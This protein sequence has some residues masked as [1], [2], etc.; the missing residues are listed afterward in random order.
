M[1][2]EEREETMKLR[3]LRR[4]RAVPV[5]GLIDENGCRTERWLVMVAALATVV[6]YILYIYISYFS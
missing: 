6:V 4:S 2:Q 3:L 1:R 5:Y